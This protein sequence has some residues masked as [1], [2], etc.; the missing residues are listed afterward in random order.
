VSDLR[1]ITLES[2]NTSQ[3]NTKSV[4][5]GARTK[6]NMNNRDRMGLGTLSSARFILSLLGILSEN[7]QGCEVGFLISVGV[8]SVIQT[9][10]SCV[11]KLFCHDPISYSIVYSAYQ[12]LSI[13]YP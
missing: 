13:L 1:R 4:N 2:R 11:G 5:R 12:L 8:L 10:L 7:L 6:E 3:N 9:L